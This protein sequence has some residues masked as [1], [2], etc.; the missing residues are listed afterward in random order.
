MIEPRDFR[1][2]PRYNTHT[3]INDIA[4]IFLRRRLTFSNRVQPI[5]LPLRTQARNRFVGSTGTIVGWGR[6]RDCKF[7]VM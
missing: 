4:L 1:Q 7:H 5:Q 2:H 3:L 6:T